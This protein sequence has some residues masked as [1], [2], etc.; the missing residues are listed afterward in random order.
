M[1]IVWRSSAQPQR[2]L[3]GSLAA[4]LLAGTYLLLPNLDDREE[5]FRRATIA[6][7]FF[8]P[9]HRLDDL[10]KEAM[11]KSDWQM[12][13]RLNSF[14]WIIADTRAFAPDDFPYLPAGPLVRSPKTQIKNA[15]ALQNQGRTQDAEAL[16]KEAEAS[17]PPGQCE[18]A[19]NL[20]VIYYNSNRKD[21][22]RQ[23]LE[24]IQPL[25]NRASRPDCVRSQFLLGSL[26]REM[27]RQDD[28]QNTFRQF[29]NNSQDS[30]DREIQQ[31]RQS[32][33]SK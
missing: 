19:T 11:D 20:A 33:N 4:L 26:Y 14:D 10:R 27:G 24:T 25:L 8:R 13:T 5:T 15:L 22:A 17:F 7:R 3:P 6:E 28:A 9:S 21:L 16:L 32:L 31:L 12:L 2:F 1:L 30:T 18:F 23:E 29:L